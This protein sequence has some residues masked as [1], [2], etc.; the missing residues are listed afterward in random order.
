[1]QSV[2]D[3]TSCC[4]GQSS[5]STPNWESHV[6]MQLSEPE[7]HVLVLRVPLIGIQA[8]DQQCMCVS[9]QCEQTKQ[10]QQQNIGVSLQSFCAWCIIHEMH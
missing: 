10:Q 6:F 7:L 1:M 3:T 2:C 4:T 5:S 8:P 9:S